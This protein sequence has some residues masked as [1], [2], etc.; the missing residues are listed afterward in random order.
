[1][2]CEVEVTTV[3]FVSLTKFRF[4][5]P[6]FCSEDTVAAYQQ[7]T[8]PSGSGNDHHSGDSASISGSN[9]LTR[10]GKIKGYGYSTS[11]CVCYTDGSGY[12]DL[13]FSVISAFNVH[14]S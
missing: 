13:P 12:V 8:C 6:I 1:M 11:K 10:Y 5:S 14:I 2:T 3:T 7:G 4:N 9:T